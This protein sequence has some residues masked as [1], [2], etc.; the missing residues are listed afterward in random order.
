MRRTLAVTGLAAGTVFAVAATSG[1]QAVGAQPDGIQG[2]GRARA[3]QGREVVI[4]WNRALL[5][6]VRTPGAQPATVHPTRGFAILHTA[7]AG[8]VAAARRGAG[9]AGEAAAA[10]AGHDS[11]AAL[12]PARR[13]DLDRRLADELGGIP[14]G[15]A[16]AA[17]IRAG[18]RA[19]AAVL[20]DRADDGSAATPPP[21]TPTGRP[22]DYRPTPPSFPAP[23]FTHWAAVRPFALGR[24]DRFRPVPPPA[25][26]TRAYARGI[27]EVQSLG[28]DTST[29]RTADQTTQARFWAAP[30]WNYW[31]EIAQSAARRHGI[32]LAATAALFAALDR[33]VA[34]S[35]IAFYD[36]KYH[37]RVWRPIT[38]IREADTDGNP[39]TH[40]DPGWNPLA[41][42]PADPSYPGA[43]SVVAEAGAIVLGSF[44]GPDDT[45]TVSSESLP[46]VTRSFTSY[47]DAADEAGLSRVYAGVHTRPDHVAGALLGVRVARF[48]LAHGAT[49]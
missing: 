5:E 33:T 38:A 10:Q 19:A 35:V 36:G 45:F 42:T 14:D 22:G 32:G 24:G 34:D 20:A 49:R 26:T 4:D 12:Y 37:Y 29:T 6:I 28:Q 17:G 27:N 9:G 44:F 7:I 11:L 1:A 13:A 15:P 41:T 30:I 46:G 43:H 18:Q 25:L 3:A 40:A 2:S 21:F 16:K 47:Q 48:D 23:V 8:G 39:D 31:N